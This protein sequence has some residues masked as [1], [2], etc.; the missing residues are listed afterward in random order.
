MITHLI[1]KS[2]L[3]NRLDDWDKYTHLLEFIST[4]KGIHKIV[5]YKFLQFCFHSRLIKSYTFKD[6]IEFKMKNDSEVIETIK[7]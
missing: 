5:K 2:L 4:T 7:I 3:K 1:K 6:N